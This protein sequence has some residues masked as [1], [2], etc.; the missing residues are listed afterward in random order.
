VPESRIPRDDDRQPQAL[1]GLSRGARRVLSSLALVWLAGVPVFPQTAPP[2]SAQTA[3]TADATIPFELVN[4]HV[5]LQVT[6]N[7]SRPLSFVLDTGDKVAILDLDR[8]KELG[9]QLGQP[10]QVGGAGGA[11]L[12]GAL[13]QG[14]TVAIPN[15]GFREAVALAIPLDA[16]ASRLG[17][18]FD[19]ILGADFI[20]QY[21]LEL[22]YQ[23]RTITL[24]DKNAFAYAGSGHSL[25]MNLDANGHPVIEADV[26][27]AG[28]DPIR[29]QFV[30]DIGSSGPLSLNT[31]FVASHHL[32]GPDV[33]TIKM[34]GGAG[35]GGEVTGTI[36]RVAALKIAGYTLPQPLTLFSED[37]AGAFARAAVQGNIGEP[38]LSRFKL[39]FDYSHNRIIFEPTAELAQPFDRAFSG[40]VIVTEGKD[41]RTFRITDL[42][43]DS[44]ATDVGLQKGDVITAID[45]QPASALT[46]TKIFDLFERP[47]AYKLTIRRG[48]ETLTVTLTP[49]KLV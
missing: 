39:Y 9:V 31:P 28:G 47:I 43:P 10:I 29:G 27:P 17:H 7:G 26:T 45:A 33:K 25:P 12:T 21:V 8:A 14:S 49:R 22:D 30:L 23:A 44:P 6:V 24:H 3:K 5:V 37:T 20:A 38:V 11:T 13:V 48:D 40:L 4:K 18:D 19:G 15:A 36:G 42:L 35:A 46:L 34:L 32:P 16:L 1:D 2:G 41:Y